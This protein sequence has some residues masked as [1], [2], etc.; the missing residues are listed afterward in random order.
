MREPQEPNTRPPSTTWE[1]RK[2]KIR[3]APQ[4]TQHSQPKAARW[5]H[6]RARDRRKPL[7]LT[8]SYRGGP[9]S[10]FEIHARGSIGRFPGW[11]ALSD[12]MAV[13]Y[14]EDQAPETNDS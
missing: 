4:A 10:W 3:S 6:M 1:W 8:I 7:T 12:V 14:G 9:E 11:V 13:I 2:T 5:Y